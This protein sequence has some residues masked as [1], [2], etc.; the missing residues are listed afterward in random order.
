MVTVEFPKSECKPIKYSEIKKCLLKR[1]SGEL[2]EDCKKFF[3]ENKI[4][5]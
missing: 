4:Q 5:D 3:Q 2:T 1:E